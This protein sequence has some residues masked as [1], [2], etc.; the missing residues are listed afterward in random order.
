MKRILFVVNSFDFFL[1]HRL[2]I[3]RRAVKE[4]YEVHIVASGVPKD[5]EEHDFTLHNLNFSRSGQNPI[6][7]LFT[8]VLLV[9]LF[10]KIRPDLVH[11]VTIKPVLYGGLAAR[12]A[13]VKSVVAA[14]SGLGTVFSASKG[15]LLIR[16]KL[17]RFLYTIALKQTNL[18]VIFQN[19]DDRKKLLATGAVKTENTVMI[20]G[21]G[22]SLTQFSMAPEPIHDITISMA[23][24]L[25]KEKG[26]CEFV[27][28]ARILK[29]AVLK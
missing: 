12:I 14:I 21:S 28:A 10:F 9:R 2:P 24:R 22:V 29:N 5:K 11:L 20:A 17:V 15:V 18:R 16:L 4:G 25:L 7:E 19:E 27:S 8:L 6:R 23:A 26:I 3:A 1:S 13:G